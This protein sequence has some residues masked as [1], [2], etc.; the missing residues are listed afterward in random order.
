MMKNIT[1]V[2]MCGVI[3]GNIFMGSWEYNELHPIE[4]VQAYESP[5]PEIILIET[6]INWTPER[7]NEE[8]EKQAE[9]YGKSAA[10]MKKIIHCESMG[11]TTVQSYHVQNGVREDSWGLVQIHLPSHPTVTKE[12][13]LDPEF[14][15]E[16]LAKNLGKV[17]WSCEKL[18]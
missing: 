14:A 17:R 3:F 5:E 9:K 16:F 18:I 1:V 4:Y 11:S 10:Y 15:I 13:A 12:Q 7:I 8:V 6:Q 2:V